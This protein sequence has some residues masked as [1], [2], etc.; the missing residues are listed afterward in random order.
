MSKSKLFWI[1]FPLA[2]VAVS[3]FGVSRYRQ[4][5]APTPPSEL[6]QNTTDSTQ[7]TLD[8][9]ERTTDSTQPTS[10][11]AQRA[12]NSAQS[13]RDFDQPMAAAVP[14][15]SNPGRSANQASAPMPPAQIT[16]PANTRIGVR[17]DHSIST[18]QVSPGDAFFATVSAPVVVNGQT[19][20]PRG[21]PVKGRVVSVHE[22]GKLKGVA[23]LR[24]ALSSVRINGTDYDLHSTTFARTGENHNKRNLV[25][26]GGGTAAGALIGALAGGGKGALIGAPAGA[27]AGTAGAALTGNKNIVLPAETAMTFQ[28][29]EPV[30]VSI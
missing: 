3:I 4:Q 13:P 1:V 30:V 26:I 12:S 10:D 2:V 15:A 8:S 21:V 18:E 14:P 7:R 24:L 29:L 23:E 11:A 16:I 9:T 6:V 17:L 28:L 20:I 27:G 5:E 22:A 19:V 25:A